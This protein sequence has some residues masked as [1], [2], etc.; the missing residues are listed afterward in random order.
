MGGQY[1]DDSAVAHLAAIVESSADAIISTSLDGT[2]VSWNAG[3]ERLYG[4]PA[5]EVGGRSISLLLPDGHADELSWLLEHVAGCGHADHIDTVHRRSDGSLTDVSL[6]LSSVRNSRGQLVGVSIIARDVGEQMRAERELAQAR[7]DIDRFYDLALEV[8]VIVNPDGYFVQVNRA[9]EETLGYRREE[10]MA[11]PVLEFLHP[12]DVGR[13]LD[14]R[15]KKDMSGSVVAFE[16]RLRHKD[17]SYRWLLWSATVAEDGLAY[18]TARD[19]THLKQMEKELRESREQALA[20]SRLKSEFVANMSHEIRTPLNGVVSMSELLMDSG[21][22]AEQHE[23]AHVAMTS[24]EALMGVVDDILDFSK[25]EAGKLDIVAEEYS[26]E[27]TLTEVCEIVRVKARERGLSLTQSIAPT[28]PALVHGDSHRVRQV[29]LNLLANAVKFTTEGEVVARIARQEPDDLLRF[30]VSDTG[31]GIDE[32]TREHLFQPFCQADAT[33]TRRYGGSGLGLCIA[34]QLVDL[35][36]GEIGV[37]STA[38]Q[39]STFWFT[40]PCRPGTGTAVNRTT[41]DLTGIRALVVNDSPPDEHGLERQLAAWGMSPASARDSGSA[42]DLLDQAAADGK[43]FAVM[44]IDEQAPTT[45]GLQLARRIKASARLRSTRLVLLSSR[46]VAP[47]HARQAGIDAAVAQPFAPSRLYDELVSV[48]SRSNR[49]FESPAR[50]GDAPETSAGRVLVAEDNE[51]NQLAARRV[52]QKLGYTVDIAHDG[53]EAIAMA[54]QTDYAAVFMDCQMPEMDGYTATAIIRRRDDAGAHVPIVAMTAHTMHGDREKC[55]SAGMDDYIA[56]PI[57]LAE[58]SRVLSRLVSNGDGPAP[59]GVGTPRPCDWPH[60]VETD[61]EDSLIDESVVRDML[62]DGGREA[63]LLDVFLRA[64]H[65]RVR[66]L[67]GAVAA[68][69]GVRAAQVAH[70][71]KGSCATFGARRMASIAARLGGLEGLPLLQESESVVG[72]LSSA[73]AATE[74]ALVEIAGTESA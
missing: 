73:L 44:L 67:A 17:G 2:I 61:S 27:A 46:L 52:L 47:L 8:M 20:A 56:K 41:G 23:Y 10:L 16:N 53:R 7:V 40:L 30:E 48:L 22:T 38:G 43:P 59:G 18:A 15:A 66:E 24:A 54:A 31:I 14:V 4:Y 5:G 21:L 50:T 6:T 42:L 45:D 39:G 11:R 71:L 37:E 72:E 29:L 25:I 12:D 70:S 69:D 28:V 36:G 60:A 35:M 64:S 3:A 1:E 65:D 34:K 57:R 55:L 62:S 19:V 9:F 68:A 13:T 32:T 49:M 33:T 63:G 51:I 58:L 74:L 26:I